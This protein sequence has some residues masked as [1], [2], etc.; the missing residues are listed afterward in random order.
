MLKERLKELKQKISLKRENIIPLIF[1]IIITFLLFLGYSLL[2]DRF[3]NSMWII[4]G[5]MLVVFIYLIMF[6]AGFA[7][8]KALFFVAA[9]LSLLIFLAQSYCDVKSRPAGSDEALQSLLIIG[10]VYIVYSFFRTLFDISKKN[11]QP[12]KN[13]K[14]SSQKVVSVAL[15]L[16]FAGVFVWQMYVVVNPVIASLCVYKENL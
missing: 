16:F 6:I 3:N 9:E 4:T 10:L 7:V 8:M 2:G 14:W 5:I 15:F 11:Y 12:V 13:E 1:S